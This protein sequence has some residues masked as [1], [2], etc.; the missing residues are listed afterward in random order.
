MSE[1][2]SPGEGTVTRPG[3]ASQEIDISRLAEELF[4]LLKEQL[5]IEAERGARSQP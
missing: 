2:P 4:K 3:I 5:R 1:Q